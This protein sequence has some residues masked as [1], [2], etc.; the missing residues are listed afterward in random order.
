MTPKQVL[1]LHGYSAENRGDGLLVELATRIVRDACGADVAITLFANHPETFRGRGLRVVDSGLR[2]TGY[3]REYLREL[4][5]LHTYDLVVGVGGGYLRFGRPVAAAK[6]LLIHIPQLVV[7][8]RSST[9]SVYLP[10]SVGPLRF[11]FR[12]LLRHLLSRIDT[13]YSRDD[14]TTAELDL[15][16]VERTPDMAIAEISADR[17]KLP[18]GGI[19]KSV[20]IIS[21]RYVDGQ[22]TG[23]LGELARRVPVFDG[24]IQSTAGANDDTAA[25]NSIGP[26]NILDFESLMRRPEEARVVVAVRMH[27]ALMAL[28]AGHYVVHLSYERKGFAAFADLGIP[29]YVHNVRSFDPAH[30]FAQVEALRT[31]ESAR[32]VYNEAVHRSGDRIVTEARKVGVRVAS[33]AARDPRGAAK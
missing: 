12:F 16:N 14:R 15:I 21:V 4:S 5:R 25:M 22:I 19:L 9:P 31:D 18:V 27:A 33:L 23:P 20:P 2:R 13:V 30:V 3:Q 7:A 29:H 17:A 6:A 26:R 1:L 24:Y 32:R 11:G 28:R 8:A 10:Q